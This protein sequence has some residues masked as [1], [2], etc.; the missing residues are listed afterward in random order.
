MYSRLGR[1]RWGSVAAVTALTV[2]AASI[3]LYCVRPQWFGDARVAFR[4]PE[5]RP[6][7]RPLFV[8]VAC[9]AGLRGLFHA[10]LAASKRGADLRRATLERCYAAHALACFVIAVLAAL[11]KTSAAT[12]A[13]QLHRF[14]LVV[15]GLIAATFYR[16]SWSFLQTRPPVERDIFLMASD[17]VQATQDALRRLISTHG[18][19]TSLIDVE[20]AARPGAA[21]FGTVRVGQELLAVATGEYHEREP[22]GAVADPRR[23]LLATTKVVRP[24]GRRRSIKNGPHER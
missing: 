17:A 7:A 18:E 8:A 14:V 23:R 9:L 6:E 19:A 4:N 2:D 22:K 10:W 1:P 5:R 15:L 16:Y 13:I 24:R 11:A 3:T 20:G 21:V 12:P